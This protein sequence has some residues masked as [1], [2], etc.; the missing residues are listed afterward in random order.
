M[1]TRNFLASALASCFLLP[2]V[3]AVRA[4]VV[5]E[6]NEIMVQ[7]AQV[8]TPDPVV[9]ART[10]AIAQVAVFEAV[11]SIVGDYEPYDHALEAPPSASADAAAIAAAHR[12]LSTLHAQGTSQ[13]DA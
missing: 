10:A 3:G 7:T 1:N 4:D 6:W 13:L 12:V 5:T 11:N 2:V 9:R 8:A